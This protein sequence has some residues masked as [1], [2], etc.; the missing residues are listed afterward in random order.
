[1][2][3]DREIVKAFMEEI[4]QTRL[5][6]EG[7]HSRLKRV[8]PLTGNTVCFALMR[9]SDR[10]NVAVAIHCDL[11]A[12]TPTIATFRVDELHLVSDRRYWKEPTEASLADPE[13]QKKILSA[14]DTLVHKHL[15]SIPK[16]MRSKRRRK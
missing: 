11:T 1:L 9:D 12:A 13:A 4:F 3:P 7:Y 15:W 14:F 16:H 8:Q 2:N 6:K 10:A 5:A